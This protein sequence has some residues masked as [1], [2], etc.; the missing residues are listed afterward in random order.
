[1]IDEEKIPVKEACEKMQVSPYMY[2]KYKK[3]KDSCWAWKVLKE[4]SITK[5]IISRKNI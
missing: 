3:I 4:F 5:L 1:M 2:R